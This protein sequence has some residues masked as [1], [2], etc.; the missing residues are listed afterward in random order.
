MNNVFAFHGSDHKCGTTMIAQSVAEAIATKEKNLKVLLINTSKDTSDVYCPNVTESLESIKPYLLEKLVDTEELVQKS[1]YKD[2]LYVIGGMK[3]P[4]ISSSFHPD[5]SEYLL[6]AA[7]NLF[8]IVI[9]DS[10]SEI[11][12]SICIGSLFYANDIYMVVTQSEAC[13]RAYEY[14]MGLYKSLNLPVRKLIIN[15]FS[16][17]AVNNKNIISSRL[18]FMPEDLITI[19]ESLYGDKAE[20][21]GKTL[22]HLKDVKFKREIEAISKD[23]LKRAGYGNI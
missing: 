1:Q 3:T 16:R 22:Y 6:A 5:M 7:S 9:C 15:K 18:K 8:D 10:G 2:N 21:E 19:G 4:G 14:M 11:E 23:I 13:L 12:N 17:N 20:L